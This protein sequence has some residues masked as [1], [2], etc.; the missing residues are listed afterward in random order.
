[1]PAEAASSW[2]QY[3]TE[4][5]AY[6]F[7]LFDAADQLHALA[8]FDAALALDPTNTLAATLR[9]RVVAQETPGGFSR[10]L[11]M[12]PDYKDIS[13]GLLGETQLYVLSNSS[14]CE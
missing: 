5:G 9:Q 7:R 13:A 6:L 14:R 4:V 12:A 11:D 2:A 8:E 3:R 1:M 10:D